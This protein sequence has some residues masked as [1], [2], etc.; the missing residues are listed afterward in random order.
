MSLV[1]T[2]YVRSLQSGGEPRDPDLFG[3]LWKKLRDALI[4]EMRKRS[5]WS[6]P[7]SYVGIYGAAGWRDPDALDELVTDC[8]TFVFLS[9]LHGLKAQ[10]R[11]KDNIEGLVFRSIQNFLYDTQ[12]RQDPLGFRVFVVL[13]TALRQA[14][15]AGVLH[16]LR[17]D[18]GVGNET[19]LGFAPGSEVGQAREAELREHVRGWNDDLLPD[20]IT[21][22]G[23]GQDRIVM[24]LSTHI[25]R[26]PVHGIEVFRFK[27]LID[28][29][30]SD[31]R[32]RWNV[33]RRYSEGE[34]A[35]ENGDDDFV[36]IV[37]RVR[38]D[39]GVEERESFDK[40]IA[41]VTEALE[42]IEESAQTKV[43]IERLWVFLRSHAAEPAETQPAADPADPKAYELPSRRKIA[44]LLGIPRDRLAGLHA[45]LGDLVEWCRAAG[46]GKPQLG[47]KTTKEG[48]SPG[49]STAVRGE[50][51]S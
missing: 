17:G 31:V 6:A 1:F 36:V 7:P 33:I 16:V 39:S 25:S 3:A 22:R 14:I 44:K 40:L 23:K 10:L 50:D 43:Y 46:S 21:A 28:L 20:L 11:V 2:E 5:L 34:T 38:P 24:R 32:A 48:R 41:C 26:L 35:I 18:P 4:A 12:K 51:G 30:K 42:R 8:F 15:A 47:S 27:D 9:R 13:Q 37:R 19:V 29:L 49:G 45:T